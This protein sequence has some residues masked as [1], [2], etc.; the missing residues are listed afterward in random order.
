MR[1]LTPWTGIQTMK[2]E[3]ER[4]VD[5]FWDGDLPQLPSMGDW[6]PAMDV[7]ETKDAVVVKAEVPGD[8]V[9]G[10]PALA[11]GPGPHAQ[12]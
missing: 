4:L 10:H 2:R 7:S 3:M 12:G 1:A 9:E 5:R 6:A 8:G 11:P